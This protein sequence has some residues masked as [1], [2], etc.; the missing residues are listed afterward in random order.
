MSTEPE[1]EPL[2]EADMQELD[3]RLADHEA[4]P[5]VGRSWA[6]VKAR[7]LGP[8][9]PRDGNSTGARE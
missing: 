6:E 4:N 1:E 9:D 3:R 5:G 7:L 8:S 2:N